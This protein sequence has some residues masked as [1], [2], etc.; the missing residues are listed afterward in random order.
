MLRRRERHFYKVFSPQ[1]RH[2][3]LRLRVGTRIRR[4]AS[5]V[6]SAIA[7]LE[8]FAEGYGPKDG[9]VGSKSELFDL[10]NGDAKDGQGQGNLLVELRAYD[11]VLANC[12]ILE[13]VKDD[14]IDGIEELENVSFD[15]THAV[16]SIR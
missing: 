3:P 10:E 2:D 16:V 9:R 11:S 5:Q 13:K 12:K 15:L 8:H 4:M 6:Y 7:Q 14:I 1:I